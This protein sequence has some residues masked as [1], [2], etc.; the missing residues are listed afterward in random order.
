MWITFE[1]QIFRDKRERVSLKLCKSVPLTRDALITSSFPQGIVRPRVEWEHQPSL[2][3]NYSVSCIFKRAPLPLH[4]TRL[5][6]VWDC[7]L[8][9]RCASTPMI[10]DLIFFFFVKLNLIWNN[11]FSNHQLASKNLHPRLARLWRVFFC[12][13]TNLAVC[14]LEWISLKAF[15]S[16]A[17][18]RS[19][20]PAAKRRRRGR[21][22]RRR[23]G[24]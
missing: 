17:S 12:T 9:I 3:R 4:S 19:N 7:R 24:A 14:R 11:P 16:S 6:Y 5:S 1:L 15:A 21:R 22:R 13:T 20:K 10:I 2:L 18:S 8:L 23:D